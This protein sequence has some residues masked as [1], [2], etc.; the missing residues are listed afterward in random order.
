MRKVRDPSTSATSGTIEV[1]CPAC[2][3][4]HPDRGKRRTCERCGIA[5]L[6]SHSYP[7]GSGLHPGEMRYHRKTF[8]LP[9]PKE[10]DD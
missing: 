3:K 6:P 2:G 8:Q 10:E 5:P 1:Q 9:I 7:R 4:V